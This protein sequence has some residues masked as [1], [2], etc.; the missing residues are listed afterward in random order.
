MISYAQNFE[1]IILNRCFRDI[2]KGFYIDVGASSPLIHSVTF[3]FYAKGWNG[4][5]VEP[6]R[7][8][9]SELTTLRPRDINLACAASNRN[10][11]ATF[12]RSRDRGGHSTI[13]QERGAALET[14]GM[15]GVETVETR[16]LADI[17][18]TYKVSRNYE[19]L[20][21]D[22]EGA[23]KKVVEGADFDRWRP[24]IILVE[25]ITSSVT[26]M[27][28]TEFESILLNNNYKY[29]FFDGINRFYVAGE[30][31]YLLTHF[32][33]PISSLD[34]AV[35]F[36]NLGHPFDDRRHPAHNF[37]RN[38]ASIMLRTVHVDERSAMFSIIT[39]DLPACY[40]NS[41]L[42]PGPVKNA[43]QRVLG[44]GPTKIELRRAVA[45]HET[46]ES[47]YQKLIDSE[48]YKL[49]RAQC[50]FAWRQLST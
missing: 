4:I 11:S 44:R 21:I 14:S 45:S 43:Y 15:A 34:N 33:A 27:F 40:L 2:E 42:S 18:S 37:A 28:N 20:K 16:T 7:E 32:K 5:N 6:F 17:C 19:F 35:Q 31:E 1:D 39:S 23:E 10:G 50:L 41:A 8:R 46:I 22:V 13:E 30:A 49:K 9:Y 25:S 48:E 29:C 24:L 3:N 12:F 38:L 36:L 26:K 47:L